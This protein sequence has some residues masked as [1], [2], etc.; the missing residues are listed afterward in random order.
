MRT[1]IKEALV[2]NSSFREY[3]KR[4]FIAIILNEE[5]MSLRYLNVM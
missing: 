3:V 5:V 1:G 4:I 2:S